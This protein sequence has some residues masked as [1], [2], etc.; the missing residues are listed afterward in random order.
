M[1]GNFVEKVEMMMM[2][3]DVRVLAV[4]DYLRKI[5]MTSWVVRNA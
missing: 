1:M 2:K 5:L 3:T 4:E